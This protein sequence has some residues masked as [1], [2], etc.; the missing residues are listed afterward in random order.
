LPDAWPLRPGRDSDGPALIALIGACWALYPGVR[1]DVDRE[2]PELHAL[3]SYY[4][5][6]LW[7][8]EQDHRIV[9]MTATRTLGDDVWEICR[10][11]VD[12]ALHGAGLAHDLLDAAESHAVRNGARRLELWS[13]TR[14]E[15]AHAFYE[16]RSYVRHGGIRVL[17][18]ISNS[19]EFGYA[20]PVDGITVLDVA[21]AASAERRLAEVLVVCLADGAGLS[22]RAPLEPARARAFWAD[23]STQVG[24]GKRVLLAGWRRGALVGTAMLDLDTPETQPH[25]AAVRMLLVDPSARRCGLGRDLMRALEHNAAAA[26]RTLLTLDTVADGAGE[27]FCRA[28]GWQETGRIPGNALDAAG[29]ERDAVLFWKRLGR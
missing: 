23:V 24:A 19:L 26:G 14:F 29:R 4:Q 6:A 1:M 17:H 15:R 16:K 13:D 12:P 22:F 21:A 27:A 18:D 10:V 11:Y 7:V 25:R 5:G 8:A 3:A 20:K 2:M 28:E 9:G